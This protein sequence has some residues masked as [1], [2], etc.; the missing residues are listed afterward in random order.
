MLAAQLHGPRR[1]EDAPL[2]IATVFEPGPRPG[3]LLIRVRACGTVALAGIAMSPIP[4]IDYGKLYHEQKIASVANATPR[5]AEELLQLAAT[6]PITTEVEVFPPTAG[7]EA[8][9]K[10]KHGATRGAGVIDM[11]R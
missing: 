4:K 9:Q 6:I 10:L 2:D 8:L 3:E 1:I 7:N 11:S 5:D